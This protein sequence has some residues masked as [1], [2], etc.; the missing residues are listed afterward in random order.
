M[1]GKHSIASVLCV[2]AL[3]GASVTADVRTEDRALV[4]FEGAL[5]K[6]VNFAT[7][8]LLM[9]SILMTAGLVKLGLP[10]IVHSVVVD[11]AF[12]RGNYPSHC[13]IDGCGLP[14]GADP[15]DES[16]VW[17]P[18][19]PRSELAG[20]TKN[21]L[22]VLVAL[23]SMKVRLVMMSP[24]AA[25]PTVVPFNVIELPGSPKAPSDMAPSTPA[26]TV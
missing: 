7:G 21:T 18:I 14:P 3:A 20:D 5:G 26:V 24:N 13:S 15:T 17:H 19:L 6:V 22:L 8:Q 9:V 10:G 4:K 11:T 23:A 25:K 2:C 12:F 1:T 16:V